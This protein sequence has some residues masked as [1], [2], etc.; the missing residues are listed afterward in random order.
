MVLGV[1]CATYGAWCSRC[2]YTFQ[3]VR[4]FSLNRITPQSRGHHAL[5]LLIVVKLENTVLEAQE[6]TLRLSAESS[7]SL[8]L[9]TFVFRV[10]VVDLSGTHLIQDF[11]ALFDV[12]F[13]GSI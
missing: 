10:D 1:W 5:K 11:P 6:C 9:G 7:M 3:A 4:R 12:E 13:V 8:W 2:I